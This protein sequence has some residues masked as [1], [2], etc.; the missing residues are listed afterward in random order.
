M[1]NKQLL[2]SDTEIIELIDL[3]PEEMQLLR[4]IRNQFR[5]GEITIRIQDGVPFRL[6]RTQE[7]ADL[8]T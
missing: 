7:F 5:F 3:R 4:L 2:Q 6:V 8:S 1:P